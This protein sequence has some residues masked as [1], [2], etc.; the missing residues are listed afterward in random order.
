MNEHLRI[1]ASVV[2][3][4]AFAVLAFGEDC[5]FPK[6]TGCGSGD[7][8]CTPGA[9]VCEQTWTK[10]VDTGCGQYG[11]LVNSGQAHCGD[12]GDV[13]IQDCDEDDPDGLQSVG[14]AEGGLCCYTDGY[15][16]WDINPGVLVRK[17]TGASCCDLT[18][19]PP[20][21]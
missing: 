18:V 19:V 14:C 16:N 13:L 11:P 17:A 7:D 9:N 1:L 5:Y 15:D 12:L 21:P 3:L 6:K 20:G 2:G 4:G 8:F 10:T